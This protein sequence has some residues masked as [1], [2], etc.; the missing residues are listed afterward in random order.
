MSKRVKFVQAIKSG[1]NQT[2]AA[3]AAGYSADSA[4]FTGSKLMKE[5]EIKR[6]LN[7][8]GDEQLQFDDPL[9]YLSHVMNDADMEVKYRID[10][11]KA[12]AGYKHAKQDAKSKKAQQREEAERVT[13]KFAPL[14]PPPYALMK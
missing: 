8:V 3:I 9:E 12:L 10:A 14:P 1:L 6:L 11:A 4:K 5:P 7:Q 2:D 13:S